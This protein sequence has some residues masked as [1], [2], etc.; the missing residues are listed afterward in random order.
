[1]LNLAAQGLESQK[2]SLAEP[3][4]W[5]LL[6]IMKELDT[7]DLSLTLHSM[8]AQIDLLRA[9]I[10]NGS[11]DPIEGENLTTLKSLFDRFEKY[12][13]KIGFN[14]LQGTVRT[15]QSAFMH[16]RSTTAHGALAH[17]EQIQG[18]F[19]RDIT[20]RRFIPVEAGMSQFVE[21]SALFG[22]AVS[23]V[24]PAAGDDI[25]EAG[26]C[27]AV[28]NSTAAVFHLMRA[29]EVGLVSLAYHFKIRKGRHNKKY[30]PIEN[31][32]WQ[33]ILQKIEIV[34]TKKTN[35]IRR[36]KAKD[37]F[38]S[39]YQGILMEIRG[40]KDAFRNQV[41]HARVVYSQPEAMRLKGHVERF[42]VDLCKDVKQ[43]GHL[44]F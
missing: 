33:G 36:G 34:V 18:A 14:D 11:R 26:N 21:S 44:S 37:A 24:F 2:R 4:L 31:L 38:S 27:L 43:P 12:A 39:R 40:F 22:E 20:E 29:V 23:T 16:D 10:R 35:G 41:S 42:M 1:M 15:A 32:D 7:Y 8:Y 17:V 13:E 5:S 25:R 9:D 6:D 19:Y 3:R 28:E 30:V